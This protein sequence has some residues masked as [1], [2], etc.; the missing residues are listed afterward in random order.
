MMNQKIP[1]WRQVTWRLAGRT[2]QGFKISQWKQDFALFTIKG[3]GINMPQLKFKLSEKL[4]RL[5]NSTK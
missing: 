5:S 4:T 3:G 2:Q 1:R